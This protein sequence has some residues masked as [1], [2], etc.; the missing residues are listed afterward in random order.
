MPLQTGKLPSKAANCRFGTL[1]DFFYVGIRRTVPGKVFSANL[2]LSTRHNDCRRRSVDLLRLLLN[3]PLPYTAIKGNSIAIAI[4]AILLVPSLKT[5][6]CSCRTRRREKTSYHPNC[7]SPFIVVRRR[8]SHA[9]TSS[10]ASSTWKHPSTGGECILT[11]T[12][13][14]SNG[15]WISQYWRLGGIE[16]S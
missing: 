10:S 15:Y 5:A 3:H 14:S 16:Y 8:R 11:V 1:F 12:G 4:F 6:D 7:P 13:V 9:V 2:S